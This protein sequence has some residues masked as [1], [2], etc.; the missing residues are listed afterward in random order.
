VGKKIAGQAFLTYARTLPAN[1]A[2]LRVRDS[3]CIPAFRTSSCLGTCKVATYTVSQI[4]NEQG[5][6]CDPTYN[7]VVDCAFSMPCICRIE[8]LYASYS[9]LDPLSPQ[10]GGAYPCGD[11]TELVSGNSCNFV[12][13]NGQNFQALDENQRRVSVGAFSSIPCTDDGWPNFSSPGQALLLPQCLVSPPSCPNVIGFKYKQGGG[14]LDLGFSPNPRAQCIGALAGDV[15][16]VSCSPSFYSPLNQFIAT[17]TTFVKRGES[18]TDWLPWN[19][20]SDDGHMRVCVC[21]GCRFGFSDNF[22]CPCLVAPF[23]APIICPT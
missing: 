15:C 2:V 13:G 4:P 9:V 6:T 12:C 17:C 19:Q 10:F 7:E 16:T 23:L 21:Q 8:D 3:D 1:S 5:V 18:V 20:I 22:A 14:K 11:C